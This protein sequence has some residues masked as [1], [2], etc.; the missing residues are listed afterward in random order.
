[1]QF[2]TAAGEETEVRVDA[3]GNAIVVATEAADQDD[4]APEGSLDA[5]T[6]E[7]LVTAALAH[8]DGTVID[9]EI[10]SD[11]A[12]PYDV[13]VLTADRTTVDIALDSDFAV[14]TADADD[15][16]D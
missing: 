9:I 12:S 6:L 13:T 1:M 16:D 4:Q 2:A 3:D 5:A 14:V 7:A 11:T 15:S 8:T 10:D